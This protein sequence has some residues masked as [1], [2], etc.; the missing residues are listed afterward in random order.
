MPLSPQ[1]KM[2]APLSCDTYAQEHDTGAQRYHQRWAAGAQSADI[3]LGWGA[4][5]AMTGAKTR[6]RVL[7]NE[8]HQQVKDLISVLLHLVLNVHLACGVGNNMSSC[9]S[10]LLRTMKTKQCMCAPHEPPQRGAHEQ[11]AALKP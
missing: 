9:M 6:D 1:K 7:L 3:K 10:Y 11:P 2:C 5:L 8:T 4:A